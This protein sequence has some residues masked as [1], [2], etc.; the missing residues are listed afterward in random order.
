MKKALFTIT[1]AF[2]LAAV[3][4][5]ALVG[6]NVSFQAQVEQSKIGYA[7]LGMEASGFKAVDLKAHCVAVGKAATEQEFN[8]MAAIGLSYQKQLKA[9]EVEAV[10]SDG[11]NNTLAE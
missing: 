11:L 2:V 5:A 4:N 8:R 9:V 6:F 3:A 7:K 1:L 10:L